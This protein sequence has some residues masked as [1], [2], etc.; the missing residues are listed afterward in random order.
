[1]CGLWELCC[2]IFVVIIC[3]FGFGVFFVFVVFI[4]VWGVVV[5]VLFSGVV[6]F[7]VGVVVVL[8][9]MVV[10]WGFV[11]W[12]RVG[13]YFFWLLFVWCIEVVDIFVE[14]LVVFWFV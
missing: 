5:V 10:K 14:M 6:M 7:V 13:E 1:M 3:G 8:I 4:V 12:I 2:V 11:G 9:V